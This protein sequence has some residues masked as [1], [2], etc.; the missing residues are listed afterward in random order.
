MEKYCSTTSIGQAGS[1]DNHSVDTL[2]K[3]CSSESEG[4]ELRS[5]DE[6]LTT[7]V[8]SRD[9]EMV[10]KSCKHLVHALEEL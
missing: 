8:N 3:G 2:G 6:E 4:S 5:L 7:S 9:E 10:H 1:L